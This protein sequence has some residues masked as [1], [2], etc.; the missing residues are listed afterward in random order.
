[1]SSSVMES[2]LCQ[3]FHR[4]CMAAINRMVNLEL[5]ASYVYL[6]MSYYFDRDDVALRHMAQF[7]R[8]Q[9]RKEREHAEK[10]LKY[11]NRRGGRIILQDIKKPERDEWGNGQEALECALQLE[12]TLNQALLD[13]H[14]LATEQ[15]DPHV[16]MICRTVGSPGS[17]S[18]PVRFSLS[19]PSLQIVCGKSLTKQNDATY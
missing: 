12:K 6:S 10:F 15:N 9:S 5:Y 4:E 16:S 2:Q 17:I 13:M 7:Q 14:K 1:M 19:P 3:N 11:Q 18:T 8:E